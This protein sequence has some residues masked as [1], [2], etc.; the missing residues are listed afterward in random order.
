M[1]Y[2]DQF[3]V[4]ADSTKTAP[5]ELK[6]I[7]SPGILHTGIFFFPAGCKGT[8]H[9]SLNQAIHQ[10]WPTNPSGTFAFENYVHVVK[11][12]YSLP[13]GIK[14]LE[15]KG[16]SVNADYD[17]VIQ[18][19]FSINDPEEIWPT[20]FGPI[21]RLASIASWFEIMYPPQPGEGD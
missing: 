14:Q 1:H 10:I 7:V 16:Y 12:Y 20:R 9:V 17:H 21:K 15:L 8:V 2:A 13:P 3:T 11:D 5:S 18:F 19:A 6:I 4:T